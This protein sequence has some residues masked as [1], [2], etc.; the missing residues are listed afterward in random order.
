MTRVRQRG[1]DG[2]CL[3]IDG[4]IVATAGSYASHAGPM[5]YAR[6]PRGARRDSSDAGGGG[7]ADQLHFR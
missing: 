4:D 5:I 7:Y 2:M 6:D 3:D 1:T